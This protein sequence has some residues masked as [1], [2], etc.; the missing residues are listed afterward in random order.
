ML[1]PLLRFSFACSAVIALS[2]CYVP[3]QQKP[4]DRLSGGAGMVQEEPSPEA[5][6]PLPWELWPH[7]KTLSGQPL[8]SRDLLYGDE[9]RES[10]KNN[11]ALDAYL[12]ASRTNL[13][14]DEA[15]AAALRVSGQYLVLDKATKALSAVGAYHRRNG[16]DEASVSPQF[17]L[18][19]AYGFGREGDINQ[20]LAWFSR[21]NSQ[22]AAMSGAPGAARQGAKMLL[23]SVP[24]DKFEDLAA[25]WHA[26]EFVNSLVGQERARRAA[27]G[28]AE[29]DP[30]SSRPFWAPYDGSALAMNERDIAPVS[31]DEA[32][33]GV[34]LS[35]TKY[36]NIGGEMKRGIEL[37]AA[38]QTDLPKVRLEVRDVGTE[39]ADS[40]AV[41]RELAAGPK[42]AALVGPLGVPAATTAR[43]VGVP[44]L[45]LSKTEPFS[46]GGGVFR[47]G[48]TT[49]SQIDA[50]V[51]T[52]YGDHKI[53]RFAI[54]HPQTASGQE[55]LE[56]LRA[57]LGALNLQLVLEVAYTT[58]DETSMLEAAQRLEGSTAEAV[59]IP[60]TI[61]VSSRLLSSLSPEARKRIRVLGTSLWDSP[62]KIAH[63]QALFNGAIF[64]APF[65]KNS[66]RREVQDFIA[67]YRGKF[68][69]APSVHAAQGF[70][71]ETIINNALKASRAKGV[72]LSQAIQSLPQYDGV[73]GVITADGGS[74]EI[75]RAL[76]VVEVGATSFQEKLPP[77]QVQRFEET[78]TARNDDVTGLSGN[79]S[80]LDADQKVSS[81]Y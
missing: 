19:L 44:L 45:S 27:V 74:G 51:N 65:F 17:G 40:S 35:L 22:S 16:L 2:A 57:K 14:P 68:S 28:W 48:M 76:Y 42:V 55:F 24:S 1:T 20:S 72:P 32:R 46:V 39:A 50:L 64:V 29:P 47:L 8:T 25:K 31:G 53:T 67:S 15:E 43:D 70:D 75:R 41:I 33:V 54:V 61:E 52:A 37:A 81:G 18:L 11:T 23:S 21:V 71:A 49:S 34:I 9:L 69:A 66:T 59:L 5:A 56:A 38:A 63:S 12:K 4:D 13:A 79:D 3:R 60:D 26:D 80:P 7:F 77:Q 58:S 73:T 6:R 30:K 10:G 62:D 36:G 78:F